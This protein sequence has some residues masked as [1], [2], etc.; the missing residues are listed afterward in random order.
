M[1]RAQNE[2]YFG[3]LEKAEALKPKIIARIDLLQ[4]HRLK[5]VPSVGV[6]AHARLV[7]ESWRRE[8]NDERPKRA[9]GVLTPASYA[10]QMAEKALTLTGK[11]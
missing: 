11:L 7:I 4:A 3:L 10:K 5:K 9:L 1:Y 6:L 8:Y 2:A